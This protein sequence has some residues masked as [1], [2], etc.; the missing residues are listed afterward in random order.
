MRVDPRMAAVPVAAPQG[1]RAAEARF[2]LGGNRSTASG[3]G[4]AASAAP[5]ATMDALLA[6]QGAAEDPAERRRRSAR[7]GHDMLD[8]LD[9]LKAALLGGRLAAADL[10]AIAGRLAERAEA[11]GDPRLDE[12]LAHI[13][14]RAEVEMAKLARGS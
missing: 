8:A 1:R 6:L 4:S 12:V 11:S 3:T 13:R 2:S 14:L 7:Q 5:L 10:T 9:R